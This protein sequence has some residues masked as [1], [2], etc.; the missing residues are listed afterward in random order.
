MGKFLFD[1]SDNQKEALVQIKN[2]TGIPITQI[3]G[4]AIDSYLGSGFPC[5][6]MTTSGCLVSGTMLV[7]SVK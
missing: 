4:N 2:S 3:I 7:V 1:L 6:I 5:N